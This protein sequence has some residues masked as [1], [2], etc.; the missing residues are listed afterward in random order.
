MKEARW[1]KSSNGKINCY[2]CPRYCKI[3][4][5]QQGFCFVRKNLNGKLYSTAYGTPCAVNM[6][7]IEKKP[8]FHFLPGTDILSLGT[9]GCNLGCIFCQNWTLTKVKRESSITKQSKE[10]LPEDVVNISLHHKCPS[11]AYTYNE[12]TIWAE[13]AVDIAKIAHKY[14]IKSVMVTNGYISDEALHDVYDNID[15]ANIDL[16]S[17][18]ENFYKKYTASYLEPV[19]KTL[20]RLKKETKVWFEI[21]TLLIPGLNDSDTEIQN[22]SKWIIDNLSPNVPIHFTAFHPEYKLLDH[23]PTA[24]ETLENA[25]LIAMEIGIKFVYVGNA[26]SDSANTYCPKCNKLLIKR[27]WHS[28]I[29]SNINNGKCSCGETIPGIWQNI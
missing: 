8:L 29:F 22:L 9:L 13:Y 25:R 5:G 21:T 17:F 7:P 14:N 23:K 19:L 15:A 1:W 26:L 6:D 16:K 12:P 3:G 11:I 4:D 28:I 20:I 2:L 10:L 24:L 27:S 18:N